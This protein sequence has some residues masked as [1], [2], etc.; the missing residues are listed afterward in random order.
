MNSALT[1]SKCC[2]YLLE[3]LAHRHPWLAHHQAVK[4]LEQSGFRSSRAQ[5]S[6]LSLL[7]HGFIEK[8]HRY[9]DTELPYPAPLWRSGLFAPDA[10]TCSAISFC[11]A[12]TLSSKLR[13]VAVYQLSP[14]GAAFYGQAYAKSPSLDCL[15]A[16]LRLVNVYLER[17]RPF[18][19]ERKN[20]WRIQQ[21]LNST[22]RLTPAMVSIRDGVAHPLILIALPP[23][24]ADDIQDAI[25]QLDEQGVRYETW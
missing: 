20:W 22:S 13:E 18:S 14:A 6:L 9:V 2:N 17:Y 11:L 5:H 12:R 16:A 10:S 7:D 19:P 8:Q 21:A 1:T 4:L 25:R 23:M 3:Q 15:T 24:H